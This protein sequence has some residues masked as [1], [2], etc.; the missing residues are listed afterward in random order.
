VDKRNIASRHPDSGSVLTKTRKTKILKLLLKVSCRWR[1]GSFFSFFYL[2]SI[3][4]HVGDRMKEQQIQRV[5]PFDGQTEKV[6]GSFYLFSIDY[7]TAI[8]EH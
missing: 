1:S 8:R 3:D 7:E 4:P 5:G 2:K 6:S